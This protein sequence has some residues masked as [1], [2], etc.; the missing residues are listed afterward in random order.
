M[1]RLFVSLILML[2]LTACGGEPGALGLNPTPNLRQ[3]T[4][5]AQASIRVAANPQRSPSPTADPGA[6]RNKL[7]E[8]RI[9]FSLPVA[10]T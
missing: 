7:P 5:T 3:Q 2:V 4:A 6:A 10:T 9:L 1:R 8:G